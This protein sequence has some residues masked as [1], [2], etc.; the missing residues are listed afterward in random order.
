VIDFGD[1]G[2]G[3]PE[4]DRT[5]VFEAFY[6]GGQPQAGPLKGTGIGLSVV[7]EFVQAHGGTVEVTESGFPG[8][9]FRL[10]L[11]ISSLRKTGGGR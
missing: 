4:A 6:T 1:T 8:A 5:R 3:I 11:P 9:H 7:K 10:R 2:P